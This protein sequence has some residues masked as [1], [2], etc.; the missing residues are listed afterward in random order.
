MSWV[1][2]IMLTRPIA[3]SNIVSP[4]LTRQ[5]LGASALDDTIPLFECTGSPTVLVNNTR[6]AMIPDATGVVFGVRNSNGTISPEE[7]FAFQ[8]VTTK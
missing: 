7:Q 3:Y 2:L 4:S 6:L 8:A 1:R 5:C